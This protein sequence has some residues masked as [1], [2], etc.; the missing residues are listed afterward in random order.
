MTPG[1]LRRMS[2][3]PQKQPPASTATSVCFPVA[4]VEPVV[5]SRSFMMDPLGHLIVTLPLS[6]ER[7]CH[8]ERSARNARAARDQQIPRF[9]RDDMLAGGLYKKRSEERRVGKECRSRWSPYH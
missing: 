8:P 3:T 1:T 4:T 6:R 7:R 5:V 9:A 2:S